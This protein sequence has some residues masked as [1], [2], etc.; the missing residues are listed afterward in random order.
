MVRSGGDGRQPVCTSRETLSDIGSELAVG[1]GS[2][3]TLEEGENARVGGLRRVKR[4]NRFDDNVVVPDN[5]PTLVQLLRCSIVGVVSVGEGTGL[6]SLDVLT[7][8]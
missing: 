7:S 8:T 5:L 6:H 4:L 1:G 3:E 2:V